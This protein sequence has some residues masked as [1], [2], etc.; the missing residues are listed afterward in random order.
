MQTPNN[1]NS[2]KKESGSKHASDAAGA[3][4]QSSEIVG[5]R[6]PAM[7]REKRD[8]DYEKT[9]DG[10]IAAVRAVAVLADGRIVTG[11]NDTTLLVWSAATKEEYAAARAEI[12]AQ[13]ARM[14]SSSTDLSFGIHAESQNSLLRQRMIHAALRGHTQPI[15]CVANIRDGRIVSGS[16]DG[17]L[18]V[19]TERKGDS[20]W[21]SDALRAHAGPITS[22]KVT[23]EPHI[24]SGSSDGTVRI[25][26]EQARGRWQC[27]TLLG[28][29]G[30]VESIDRFPNGDIL[31]GGA[32]GTVRIW[33]RLPSGWQNAVTVNG[34]DPIRAVTVLGNDE[35]VSV[36]AQAVSTFR[37]NPET[38]MWSWHML[39]GPKQPQVLPNGDLV[40]FTQEPGIGVWRCN[41]QG[42]WERI[43]FRK[44]WR[45]M[46]QVTVLTCGGILMR[47]GWMDEGRWKRDIEVFRLDEDDNLC[48]EVRFTSK[49]A[50]GEVGDIPFPDGRF[51]ILHDDGGVEVYR[52]TLV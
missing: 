4:E 27:E 21:I 5:A 8:Y 42:A 29:T 43:A 19:W 2:P 46:I 34:Y 48:F 1:D 47:T 13:Y 17:T 20:E 38:Q 26:S 41:E 28:H 30:G 16:A 25:W 52:G 36:G 33:H 51:G 50:R 22:V 35:F 40:G 11:G 14:A 23:E 9:L 15:T 39:E 10:H 3:R 37:R 24:I 18:R 7:Q 45:D 49:G 31:S 6:M 44:D 32:D 12:R